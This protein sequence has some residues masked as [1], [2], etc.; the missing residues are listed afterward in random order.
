[1]T[2]CWFHLFIFIPTWGNDPIWLYDVFQM[3]WNHKLDEYIQYIE[4]LGF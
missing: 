4:C 2:R 1:M 3:G